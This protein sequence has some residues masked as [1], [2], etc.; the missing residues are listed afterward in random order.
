MAQDIM[1]VY[2]IVC[3]GGNTLHSFGVCV[4][5][6]CKVDGIVSVYAEVCAYRTCRAYAF[7]AVREL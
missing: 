3:F 1:G 5:G 7:M 4:A 2:D 6:K